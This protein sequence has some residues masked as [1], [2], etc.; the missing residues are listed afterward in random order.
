MDATVSEPGGRG[1]VASAFAAAR[2]RWILSGFFGL[3]LAGVS[4]SLCFLTQPQKYTVS[5]T[6]QIAAVESKLLSDHSDPNRSQNEEYRRAQAALLKTRP[7]MQE[8][9][10]SNKVSGLVTLARAKPDPVTWLETEIKTALSDGGL[11]RVSL[12]GENVDEMAIILNAV[13][14]AY[15][16]TIVDAEK[17]ERLTKIDEADKVLVSVEDR[18]RGQRDVLRRLAETLKTS[19]TQALTIK[20]QT[21]LQ[22][23]A[24]LRRELVLLDSRIRSGRAELE[25]NRSKAE[26]VKNGPIAESLINDGLSA[27]P[28][29]RTAEAE[30][31]K[32]RDLFDRSSK[33]VLPGSPALEEIKDKVKKAEQRLAAT[34]QEQR[35]PIMK[36][37]RESLILSRWNQ[38]VQDSS[39]LQVVEKERAALEK[40]VTRLSLEAEKIGVNSFELELKRAEIAEADTIVK[41]LRAEKE[42]LMIDMQTYKRRVTIPVPADSAFAKP[43]TSNLV[44][45]GAAAAC[46]FLMGVFS[47][48]YVENRRGRL[49]LSDDLTRALKLPVIGSVPYSHSLT[50]GT[51]LDTWS[52][53]HDVL[54]SLV[55]EAVND[56]RVKLLCGGGIGGAKTV[57]ITSATQGE[58]KTTLVCLLAAS[59]SLTQKKVLIIDCDFRNPRIHEKFQ[60]EAGIGLSEVLRGEAALTQAIQ[61]I[62][63]SN[64]AILSTGRVCSKVIRGITSEAIRTVLDP[65]RGIYDLILID[66]C[67]AI[68]V[69]DALVLSKSVDAAILAISS[70]YSTASL[71]REAYQRLIAVDAPLVGAVLNGVSINMTKLRYPSTYLSK[72]PSDFAILS[73]A[74]QQGEK[75]S[76]QLSS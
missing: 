70:G 44:M 41:R 3:L 47:F 35:E 11:L 75:D 51:P 59:I 34:R 7:V 67:P 76:H 53:R 73:P 48:G 42:R 72:V 46:G 26:A 5:T 28:I 27:D 9:L 61:H 8:A 36:K 52:G 50:S 29:V 33:V 62:S 54:G 18:L 58:G 49:I 40:D 10:K 66:S 38:V 13:T 16:K 1:T 43:S 60:R 68:P 65:L 45:A 32:C 31:A 21:V 71:V 55:I 37:V 19:D 56:I 25:D 17:D 4:G 39:K 15:L 57:L 64:L 24:S 14:A 63:E 23:Y 2:R 30:A 22:E 6:L 20:Q 69:A 12:T 74:L